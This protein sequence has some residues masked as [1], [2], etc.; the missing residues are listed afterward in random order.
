MSKKKKLFIAIGVILIIAIF[1]TL[2]LLKGKGGQIE[3]QV[4]QVKR[5]DIT[6][7]V[8]GTGRIQPELEIKI[9]A[10]VSG[11]IIG[12]YVNEGDEVKKGDLLVELDRKKYEAA[13]VRAKSNLKSAQANLKKANSDYKRALDLS[14]QKLISSAEMES[15]EAS[16]LLA[17]S[18]VEQARANLEQTNDDLLKTKIYS[19]INGVVTILN[20]ELG[21]IALGSTFQAD[22]IMTVADLSKMEVLSEVDENDVVMVSIDDTADIEVDALPDTTLKGIVSEIA[23][24]ATTRGFGTQEEVTNFEVKVAVL[25]KIEKLRPG[26]S[27][28]VDIRTEIHRNVLHVPIQAVT[29]RMPSEIKRIGKKD[30]DK[31][32]ET[33]DDT[34]E[35]A[36]KNPIQEDEAEMLEVVFVVKGDTAKIIPVTTGISNDTD[37]EI[38]NGVEQE[39]QVVVGSYRAI[40]KTLK[41]GSLVKVSSTKGMVN[42]AD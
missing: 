25:D 28:T 17:E 35:S 32:A 39:M 42:R 7:V 24:A 1:V 13:V 33:T 9:S 18:E 6:Q 2:N 23:H 21:E 16:L 38:V 31:S 26:M 36:Q 40:S 14:N 37:I 11:E 5:G 3:V 8:S 22:V 10:N 19:P 20:K 27:S 41:D 4:E 12:L 30:E 29:V 15:A 34:T